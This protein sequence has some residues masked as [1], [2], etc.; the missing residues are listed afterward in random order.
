M[1]ELQIRVQPFYINC[2]VKKMGNVFCSSLSCKFDQN[3]CTWMRHSC[4]QTSG[5]E[6]CSQKKNQWPFLVSRGLTRLAM[7]YEGQGGSKVG[8]GVY[9]NYVMYEGEWNFFIGGG[10]EVL[11]KIFDFSKIST[12]PPPTDS[13]CE[14]PECDGNQCSAMNGRTCLEWCVRLHHMGKLQT[15]FPIKFLTISIHF[16]PGSYRWNVVCFR[17]PNFLQAI[18]VSVKR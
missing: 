2:Q 18:I 5:W 13:K 7:Y 14:V 12:H 10:G 9:E 17:S 11:P 1:D 15:K 4:L 6:S 16:S 3:Q 8:G